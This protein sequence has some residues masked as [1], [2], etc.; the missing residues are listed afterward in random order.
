MNRVFLSAFQFIFKTHKQLYFGQLIHY[1]K[2]ICK[3]SNKV[4]RTYV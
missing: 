3:N 2:P 1:W 4:A